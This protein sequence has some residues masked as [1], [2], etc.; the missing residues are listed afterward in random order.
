MLVCGVLS[1]SPCPFQVFFSSSFHTF[2]TFFFASLYPLSMPS[3][4]NKK[5]L[6]SVQQDTA[7]QS[8]YLNIQDWNLS[9]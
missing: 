2:P 1:L 8:D 9:L 5:N 7:I 4:G 6:I 3:Y